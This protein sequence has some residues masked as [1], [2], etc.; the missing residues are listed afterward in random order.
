M[1]GG[2][3]EVMYTGMLCIEEDVPE[4]RKKP[5]WLK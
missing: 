5:C 1:T 3:V 4:F 2:C